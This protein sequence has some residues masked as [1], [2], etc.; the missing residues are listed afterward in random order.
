MRVLFVLMVSSFVL[1]LGACGNIKEEKLANHAELVNGVTL[2][3]IAG[4]LESRGVKQFVA[5]LV[6]SGHETQVLVSSGVSELKEVIA[7][8]RARL[9]FL[10]DQ[11]SLQNE[12]EVRIHQ[13][14]DEDIS[15]LDHAGIVHV[16]WVEYPGRQVE[17]GDRVVSQYV[18]K[19]PDQ[20]KNPNVSMGVINQPITDYTGDQVFTPNGG[21]S[22][23]YTSGTLQKFWLDQDA[24]D[25]I[26]F[27]EDGLE[28]DTI[29]KPKTAATC[30]TS[31]VSS[32]LPSYY[33]DT[34]F[35]DSP[36]SRNCSVGSISG[37]SLEPWTLYWTWHP[38][39]SFS[40][41]AHIDVQYQPKSWCWWITGFPQCENNKPWCMCEH[42]IYDETS[43]LISYYYSEAPGV[44]V[45]WYKN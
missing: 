25:A 20:T 4:D 5:R 6:Y 17:L 29:I 14:F 42:N 45:T 15:V 35:S 33:A 24:I 26:D 16:S 19:K 30:N 22:T 11:F 13:Q 10:R 36:S 31:G 9:V 23:I 38:F 28:I 40:T 1:L 3:E 8:E 2:N 41:S 18:M 27:Y 37:M 7:A 32:N 43:W 34:E 12:Q 21:T 44:E 39:S